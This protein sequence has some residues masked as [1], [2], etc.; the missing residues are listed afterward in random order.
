MRTMT[1]F[2][3]PIVKPIKPSGEGLDNQAQP[4]SGSTQPAHFSF[5]N[6]KPTGAQNTMAASLEINCFPSRCRCIGKSDRFATAQNPVKSN[7]LFISIRGANPA[8][9]YQHLRAIK[10]RS[11]GFDSCPNAASSTINVSKTPYRGANFF[12]PGTFTITTLLY[13]T[14]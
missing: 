2:G 9:L 5:N 7:V 8:N 13:H 4:T 14:S 10:G 1:A 11:T 12:M 6:K 3:R